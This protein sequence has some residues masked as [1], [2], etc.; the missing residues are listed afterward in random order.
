MP[1][2]YETYSNE[3]KRAVEDDDV[4]EN[5]KN[6][7]KINYMIEEVHSPE[8]REYFAKN[9]IKVLITKYEHILKNLPWNQYMENDILG[10]PFLVQTDELNKYT[11]TVS[12]SHTTLRYILYSLY[13]Y[14][15]VSSKFDKKEISIVEVGSGYGGQCKILL[16]TFNHFGITVKYTLIDLLEVNNLSKKY[17]K[18]ICPRGEYKCISAGQYKTKKEDRY[19]LFFSCFSLGEMD[20]VYQ[21]DYIDNLVN[22][23]TSA[24][25][26]WNNKFINPKLNEIQTMDCD[27]LLPRF[28]RYVSVLTFPA[29]E[30]SF[31]LKPIT[32]S[33]ESHIVIEYLKIVN[34]NIDHFSNITKIIKDIGEPVEEGIMTKHFN[35][36]PYF[37][38]RQIDLYLLSKLSDNILNIGFNAGHS[39]LIMLLSNPSSVITCFDIMEHVYTQKCFDYLSQSF[40]G[41]VKLI[42]GDS[43]ETVHTYKSDKKFGLININGGHDYRNLN[44]DFWNS[45]SLSD[46]NAFLIWNN[47]DHYSG[48]LTL[49][50]GFVKDNQINQVYFLSN[51]H[52]IGQF[53]NN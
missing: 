7:K 4:F 19:D 21:D 6:N 27:T 12:F 46:K 38:L 47:L 5:F 31:P 42:E 13:L 34:N 24:Y 32:S 44:L 14:D 43:T 29:N 51:E 3:C 1:V 52:Y 37:N 23:C 49:W 20:K 41:R 35:I 45:K 8:V 18:I 15:F 17:L 26:I 48:G 16:D 53:K 40:P 11:E 39:T 30:L 28:D 33:L 36:L 2:D 25:I 9:F 50:E 22:T 10:G